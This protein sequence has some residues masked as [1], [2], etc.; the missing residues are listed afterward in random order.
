MLTRRDMLQSLGAAGVSAAALQAGVASADMPANRTA[1]NFD[2]PAGACDCHVHV[3]DREIPVRRETHLH[4]AQRLGRGAA[5]AAAV[6]ASRPRRGRAAERLCRRQFG[7]AQRHQAYGRARPRRCRD[8][9]VDLSG[10][11]RRYGGGRRPRRAAQSADQYGRQVRC[12]RGQGAARHDRKAD[13]RARLARAVLH[14]PRQHLGAQGPLHAVAVP[15]GVRPFRPRRR[16]T[17]APAS[18]ASMRCSAG[19][20][21]HA[22]VKISAAYRVSKKASGLCR[23]HAAGA[24]AGGG[25]CRPHRLG[26]RL[27]ASGFRCRPRQA[28]DRHRRAV[29]DRRRLAV[30]SIGE[31]GAGRRRPQEDP[32]RQSG[33]AL[34]LRDQGD[35]TRRQERLDLGAL[36]RAGGAAETRAFDRG[37]RAGEAQRGRD[38]AGLRPVASVKA[39]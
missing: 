20:I 8:R 2:V 27:A 7:D 6:A 32:G 35:L 33:P 12:G 34:R 3:F 23:R 4:T 28:V 11:H 25:E 39:A 26:H 19:Q 5:A 16:R 21:G 31:V 17:R 1:P 37:R 13:R 10:G 15:G 24:G 36:G 18:P 38:V 30:Q 14:R 29:P 9:Q 22:Y